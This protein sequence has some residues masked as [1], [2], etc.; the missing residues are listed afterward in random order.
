M[1]IC[2]DSNEPA[3]IDFVACKLPHGVLIIAV[4][5]TGPLNPPTR[6]ACPLVFM[7]NPLGFPENH[8]TVLLGGRF[9]TVYVPLEHIVKGPLIESTGIVAAEN[10]AK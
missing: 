4:I 6:D 9:A 1:G 10:F 2:V 5:S 8:V 3:C 7:L